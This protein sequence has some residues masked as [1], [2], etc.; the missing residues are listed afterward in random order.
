MGDL[1]I[2]MPSLGLR[3]R[4]RVHWSNFRLG[5]LFFSWDMVFIIT[6]H[7]FQSTLSPTL[8]F[9][10]SPSRKFPSR[11]LVTLG[12]DSAS[13]SLCVG[14]ELNILSSH[15]I[16]HSAYQVKGLRNFSKPDTAVGGTGEKI[17]IL[18]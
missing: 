17:L 14:L 9:L 3:G 2:Y 6:V 1:T 10:L 13:L 4:K 15:R 5:I 7:S 12:Y 16:P 8:S 11:S 18:E